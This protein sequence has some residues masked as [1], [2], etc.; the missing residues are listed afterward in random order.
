MKANP[1]TPWEQVEILDVKLTLL[2]HHPETLRYT[3][4][5]QP[6]CLEIIHDPQ[7]DHSQDYREK[8]IDIRD[9]L[10]STL[11]VYGQ[12]VHYAASQKFADRGYTFSARINERGLLTSMFVG[13]PNKAIHLFI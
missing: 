8:L 11:L 7:S 3:E 10:I 12:G 9:S 2:S 1:A 6:L 4:H 5:K 13:L